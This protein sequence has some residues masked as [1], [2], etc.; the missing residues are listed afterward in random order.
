MPHGRDAEGSISVTASAHAPHLLQPARLAVPEHGVQQLAR[1]RHVRVRQGALHRRTKVV[2]IVPKETAPPGGE[3]PGEV[4]AGT[5]G[6]LVEIGK[7]TAP[8]FGRGRGTEMC[9]TQL[10]QRLELREAGGGTAAIHHD[11]RLVDQA[12]EH[13]DNVMRLQ[14]LMTAHGASRGGIE[15]AWEDRQAVEQAPLAVV[16]Q[17]IRPVH[18]GVQRLVSFGPVPLTDV[19]HTEAITEPVGDV[20]HGQRAHPSRRQLDGQG[21]AIEVLTDLGDDNAVL[22]RHHEASIRRVRSSAEQLLA[23]NRRREARDRVRVLP[24]HP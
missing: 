11:H 20:T 13:I 15:R 14:R 8:V 1:D 17:L 5:F 12:A 2:P 3:P 10:A 18:C 19:Q 9:H 16:E 7:M 4:G 23:F 21:Y 22:S 24:L 6:D